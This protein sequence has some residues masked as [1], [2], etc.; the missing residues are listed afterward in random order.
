MNFQ[1]GNCGYA[2]VKNGNKIW[3]KSGKKIGDG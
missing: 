3:G 2:K 1:Y